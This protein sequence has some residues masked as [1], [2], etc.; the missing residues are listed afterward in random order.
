MIKLNKF[1]FVYRTS[2]WW[3]SDENS[4]S[5]VNLLVIAGTCL[6]LYVFN[7]EDNVSDLSDHRQRKLPINRIIRKHKQ[8]SRCI[9]PRGKCKATFCYIF[10]LI[11]WCL[12][13]GPVLIWI[14]ELEVINIMHRVWNMCCF[15]RKKPFNIKRALIWNRRYNNVAWCEIKWNAASLGIYQIYDILYRIDVLYKTVQHLNI[16]GKIHEQ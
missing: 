11:I 16:E 9:F 5:E 2:V 12:G 14:R 15:G 4:W 1:F 6:Y 7:Q 3:C 8:L 10:F 13:F